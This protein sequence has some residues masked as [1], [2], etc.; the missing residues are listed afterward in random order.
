M[1]VTLLSASGA[2]LIGAIAAVSKARLS[3]SR[4]RGGYNCC[5]YCSH[6][7]PRDPEHTWRY[8]G[9]CWKC[10]RVQPWATVPGTTGPL[11]AA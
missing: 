10:G 2:A 7:L 8:S 6:P 5:E 9:T 4:A 1:T 11:D 3:S